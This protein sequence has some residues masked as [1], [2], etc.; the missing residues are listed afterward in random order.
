[1]VEEEEIRDVQRPFSVLRA[2]EP[3]TGTLGSP[4]RSIVEW[5]KALALDHLMFQDAHHVDPCS[6]WHVV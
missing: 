2:K 5:S 4:M 6:L 1:M 3:G